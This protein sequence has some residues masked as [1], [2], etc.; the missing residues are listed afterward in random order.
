MVRKP[1]V[2]IV[3]GAIIAICLAVLPPPSVALADTCTCSHTPFGTYI[4]DTG[5][6]LYRLDR[7]K[8]SWAVFVPSTDPDSPS[9]R[10]AGTFV[11]QRVDALRGAWPRTIRKVVKAGS[12]D[13]LWDRVPVGRWMLVG[14]LR[15][16]DWWGFD[17]SGRL[18]AFGWSADAPDDP[19]PTLAG[20]YAV[21]AA[22]PDT[23]TA[24][25]AEHAGRP[26]LPAGPPL[27]LLLCALGGFGAGLRRSRAPCPR[28]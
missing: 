22:L 16:A 27:V 17:A 9:C 21:M 8:S 14:D 7:A 5:V 28:P 25:P 13:C 19:P 2:A 18:D 20:W 26:A 10:I 12:E 11:F 23:S 6:A 24:P 3:G 4:R 1:P 15:W